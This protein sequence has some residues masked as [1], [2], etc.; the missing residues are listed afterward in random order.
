MFLITSKDSKPV[1]PFT[2]GTKEAIWLLKEESKWK[3]TLISLATLGPN[4]SGA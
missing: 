3:V 1:T 4:E 2:R